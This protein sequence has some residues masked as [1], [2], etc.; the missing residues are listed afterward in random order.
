ALA[1]SENLAAFAGRVRPL[2]ERLH[3]GLRSALP[4]LVLNGHPE[5]RLPNTLNVS[6]PGVL[7]R[8]V[9]EACPDLAASTG[10]ACHEGVDRPSAVLEAMGVPAEVAL[11]ALR[12]SL[13]LS[14]TREDVDRATAAIVAAVA[15]LRS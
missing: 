5:Q 14:T 7:G 13:T 10:S 11:G 12:L 15:G 9:L 4:D 2:R 6:V 1:R 3:Q 8:R